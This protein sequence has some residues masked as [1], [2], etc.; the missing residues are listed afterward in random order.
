MGFYRGPNIVTDGLVFAV[1]A[2]SARSYPGSG[3]TA[4][5][6]AG[7]NTITLDNGVGFS[8][9]NG[10]TFV[11]DGIDDEINTN[12]TTQYTDFS[13]VVIFKNNN[14]TSWGRL[15]DKSYSSGFF[16]SAY[17]LSGGLGY[18]GAG[19]IEPA[20]P[21]GQSLQYDTSV[22]NYFVV[23]RSGTTHTIYLNGSGTSA[24]KTGSGSAISANSMSIGAWQGSTTSQRFTGEI[25]VVKTYNR[26]LTAAEVDQD[27]NAYRNRFGI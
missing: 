6:L 10:G 14:T 23:T 26:A 2:A 15:V 24:S 1:D 8:S 12:L 11:F 20:N 13:C 4:T 17:F 27:F 19:I 21:H 3:T 25:P 22:Y 16:I 9:T 5:D 18:V 7:T